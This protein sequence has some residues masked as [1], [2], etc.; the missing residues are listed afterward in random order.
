MYFSVI[1]FPFPTTKK[2]TPNQKKKKPS[3]TF[4][5]MKTFADKSC[6]N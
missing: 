1:L 6:E 5:S 3:P 2:P 4:S